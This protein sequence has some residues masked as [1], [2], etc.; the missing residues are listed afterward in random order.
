MQ[1]NDTAAA[2]LEAYF[3]TGFSH[4][5]RWYSSGSQAAKSPGSAPRPSN[6]TNSLTPAGVRSPSN[7]SSDRGDRSE[8]LRDVR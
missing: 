1:P 4:M 6:A 2:D 7:V 8:V 3:R 5:R